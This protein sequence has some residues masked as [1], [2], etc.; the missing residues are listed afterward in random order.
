MHHAPE[1]LPERDLG[2]GLSLKC[3]RDAPMTRDV[4]VQTDPIRYDAQHER[5]GHERRRRVG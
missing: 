1:G 2:R 5:A 4:A 3:S